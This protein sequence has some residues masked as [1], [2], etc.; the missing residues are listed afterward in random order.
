MS[1]PANES[2][3]SKVDKE[4][5]GGATY[6]I[7]INGNGRTPKTLCYRKMHK[8]PNLR[9]THEAGYGTDHVGTGACKY[10]GG[11]KKTPTITT[12]KH[13]IQT[14]KRLADKIETYL[15]KS[16]DELLDL[17]EQLAATRA[18]FDEF[19]MK[20]PTTDDESYGLW[21]NRFNLLVSTLGTLVEKISRVDT[22]NT[23]TAAQVLYLRATMID[24]LLKYV[25]DPDMRE[26]VVREIATRM[27]GDMEVSMK[28]SE[29]SLP[30][31]VNDT[32]DM[33]V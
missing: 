24:I 20:F 23:L 25:P 13:A 21:F 19:M 1:V 33:Q 27:G 26:R 32:I 10:H 3:I 5:I 2:K 17:T 15:M 9:C 6:W 31:K 14:K 22:R 4:T 28:P 8:D 7:T 29:V 30:Y 18:I 16:R 12:G 11:A